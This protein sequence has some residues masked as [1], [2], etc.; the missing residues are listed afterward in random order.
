MTLSTSETRSRNWACPEV[1]SS[2]TK[3][4]GEGRQK[5]R[6]Q[7]HEL[8]PV[9]TYAIHAGGGGGDRKQVGRGFLPPLLVALLAHSLSWLFPLS[10]NLPSP[11]LTTHLSSFPRAQGP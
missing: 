7:G 11:V 5:W 10:L 8:Q 2:P 6:Q 4:L 1:T 3:V 9:R